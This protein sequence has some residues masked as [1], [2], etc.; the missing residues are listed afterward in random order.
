MNDQLEDIGHVN[1]SHI[2]RIR[3]VLFSYSK[4]NPIIGYTQGMNFILGRMIQ[5]LKSDE[6]TFWTFTMLLEKIL[7][8]D[9]YIQMMGVSANVK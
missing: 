7:P 8:F 6:E 1:P 9:Y 4:R 2:R 3:R 5:V